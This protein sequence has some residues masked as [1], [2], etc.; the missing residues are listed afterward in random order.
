MRR[1]GLN[2]CELPGTARLSFPPFWAGDCHLRGH[3]CLQVAAERASKIEAE[4]A[5][6]RK[7]FFCELCSK[8]YKLATEY[9]A[10]LSSYDHNHK[11]VRAF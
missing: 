5:A 11:K 9:E 2:L 8:Q 4:V 7:T 6:M 1:V 3:T 10:H